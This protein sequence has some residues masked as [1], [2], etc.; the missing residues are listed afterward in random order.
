[1]TR[2][3]LTTAALCGLLSLAGNLIG[4]YVASRAMLCVCVGLC[5]LGVWFGR[6]E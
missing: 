1:M 3:L 5:C 6:G 4:A 2:T